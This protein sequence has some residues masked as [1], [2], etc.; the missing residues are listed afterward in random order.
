MSL[1]SQLQNYN[2][3]IS[4]CYTITSL[5]DKHDREQYK[6]CKICNKYNCKCRCNQCR[7]SRIHHREIE[8]RDILITRNKQFC[9]NLL[10]QVETVDEF[11]FIFKEITKIVYDKN[12]L[13]SICDGYCETKSVALIKRVQYCSHQGYRN[14][15]EHNNLDVVKHILRN[16]W[17]IYYKIKDLIISCQ[18]GHLELVKYLLLHHATDRHMKKGFIEACK[19]GHINIVCYITEPYINNP[20]PFLIK[21]LK[22]AVKYKKGKIIKY[23]SM[24]KECFELLPE[25]KQILINKSVKREY[26]KVCDIL[27]QYLYTVLTEIVVCYFFPPFK[28]F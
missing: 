6:H 12:D 4:G 10:K 18:K 27:D 25:K 28:D 23:L 16:T 15:I 13:R 14:A 5:Y 3:K 1:K 17:N 9:Y 21:G 24:I 22:I 20:P 8:T 19:Y 2:T 7:I 26:R 11:D